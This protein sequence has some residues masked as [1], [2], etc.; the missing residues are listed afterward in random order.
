M[1]DIPTLQARM[2]QA[3]DAE[4]YERAA[5]LRDQLRALGGDEATLL[6]GSRLRRQVPGKMGLG[7]DQSDHLPPKDWKPPKRPD[8]MTKGHR[9]RGGREG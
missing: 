5:D 9:G 7:T 2:A 3:I 1:S 8:P 4:D 6:P